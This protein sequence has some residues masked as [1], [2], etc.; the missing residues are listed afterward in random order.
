MDVEKEH[1]VLLRVPETLWLEIKRRAK[2]DRR[3]WSAEA[4]VYIEEAIASD[5]DQQKENE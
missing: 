3:S 4:L 5:T 2:L 1:A